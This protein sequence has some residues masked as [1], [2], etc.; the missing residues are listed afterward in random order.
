M[1][2]SIT[3]TL[4]VHLFRLIQTF[5]KLPRKFFRM[6]EKTNKWIFRDILE[7]FTYL[8]MKMYVVYTHNNCLNE[9]ILM[10]TLNI[11]LFYRK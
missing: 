3:R 4:M 10:S 6:L 7:K 8:I 2:T 9:A 11:A 5:F 1:N